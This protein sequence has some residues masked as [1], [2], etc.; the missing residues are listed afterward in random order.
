[1]AN[2]YWT[3]EID[4]RIVE[5][6]SIKEPI[7]KSIFFKKHLYKPFTK[8]IQNLI[9]KFTYYRN[10]DDNTKKE[11]EYELLLHCE[12]VTN[13]YNKEKDHSFSYYQYVIRNFIFSYIERVYDGNSSNI[14]N[15][16]FN[17]DLIT[18]DKSEY[19]NNYDYDDLNKDF[20]EKE[21]FIDENDY[22]IEFSNNNRNRILFRL[23]E[24][25]NELL[26]KSESINNQKKIDVVRIL[27]K[28]FNSTDL[29]SK[30]GM[31]E[32]L[33]ENKFS[34]SKID[35]FSM[36]Y[37]KENMGLF[38]RFHKHNIKDNIDNKYTNFEW[39][40]NYGNEEITDEDR[41]TWRRYQESVDRKKEKKFLSDEEIQEIE[42]RIN[43]G[44]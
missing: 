26:L 21:V 8:L 39:L 28:Y 43:K 42:E 33:Q 7:K 27:K 44:S 40:E 38:S 31:I 20:S 16:E 14:K 12:T 35:Q 22:D 1:V 34:V 2:W 9:N 10:L 29:Y 5:Y 18:K 36:K 4:D 3:P 15:I 41:E 37:F 6:C 19:E 24:I 13:K 17:T 11:L 25:E 32:F 30:D 23:T